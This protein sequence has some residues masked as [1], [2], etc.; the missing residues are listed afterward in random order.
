MFVAAGTAAF[1]VL[2]VNALRI[3]GFDCFLQCS[4][5]SKDRG[6]GWRGCCGWVCVSI[7]GLGPRT[8]FE[9]ETI[10]LTTAMKNKANKNMTCRTF[11]A[12]VACWAASSL[13]AASLEIQFDDPDRFSDFE[14]GG[15]YLDEL[16]DEFR[17]ELR[18]EVSSDLNDALPDGAHL[19]ITFHDIDLAGEYEPWRPQ[20]YDVR[21][22]RDIYPPR[23]KFHYKV[24]A[25]DREVL[26]EGMAQ[27]TDTA[28][29]W[30]L[31]DPGSHADSFYFEQELVEN[32]VNG[33]LDDLIENGEG[34][35]Q[36]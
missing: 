32:W 14:Q 3:A 4:M 21:I 5:P 18:T 24:V 8:Q 36:S 10:Q 33:K 23:L 19:K 13:S 22:V 31:H 16:P 20:A 9:T 35:T 6:Q 7:D 25:A 1:T 17:Q 27:L 11:G 26:A 34:V 28:F 2:E 15:F 29:L 12:L 30:N